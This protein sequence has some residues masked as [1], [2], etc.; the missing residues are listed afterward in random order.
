MLYCSMMA[1]YTA[2]T[3]SFEFMHCLPTGDEIRDTSVKSHQDILN[4]LIDK[5]EKEACDAMYLHLSDMM[6]I[7]QALM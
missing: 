7:V 6:N 4:A 1:I 3:D 5:N 2:V